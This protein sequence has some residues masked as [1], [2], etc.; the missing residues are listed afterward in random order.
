MPPPKSSLPRAPEPRFSRSFDPWN[1]SSTGH[2]RPEVRPTEGWRDNRNRK[3]MSQFRGGLSGGERLSDT[4]GAGSADFDPKLGM[5]VP[6]AL[7]ARSAVSVRDMLAQ[8]GKMRETLRRSTGDDVSTVGRE[9]EKMPNGAA[10]MRSEDRGD[11]GNDRNGEQ[12]RSET[13][14]SSGGRGIFDGV[15]V[16]V[17]GSTAPL[18][19]DHRLK[20]ILVE[21][22]A[23]VSLHLGRRQVTHVVIG[24]P[25]SGGMGSGGALAGGKLEKEIRTIRGSGVQYVDVEW[26][27][28]SLKAGK[29]LPESRF[30]TLK[31]AREGQ[32]SVYGMYPART[33]SE[34]HGHSVT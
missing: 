24:R 14:A 28:E 16:Y 21:Q 15:V 26:V 17:N 30:A 11:D 13:Q 9:D 18:V 27:L 8:P 19:S 31:V 7:R 22:G 3:L 23:K 5:V 12:D 4:V 1:S 10:A 34:T 25:V 2:Q 29:R 6:R 32:R 20:R 33:R